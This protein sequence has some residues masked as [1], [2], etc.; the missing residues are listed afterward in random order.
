MCQIV[1]DLGHS[2][3]DRCRF[4]GELS[5]SQQRH[6][7]FKIALQVLPIIERLWIGTW[8]RAY[9]TN[10]DL[11]SASVTFGVAGHQVALDRRS[12]T[13]RSVT[14]INAST[15]SLPE[16]QEHPYFYIC[17][18]LL[19]GVATGV[20][21]MLSVATQ[22]VG[23]F[24]ASRRLFRRLFVNIIRATMRWHVSKT[25]YALLP[26]LN[27]VNIDLRIQLLKVFI[28]VFCRRISPA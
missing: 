12:H 13:I 16:A 4:A 10:E 28:A 3:C 23:A 9:R 11:R 22:Y 7:D 8:S 19:I 1:L 27:E 21:S 17:I 24:R 6:I 15:T 2:Y 18:F 25:F 5:S 14:T 26:G 20:A